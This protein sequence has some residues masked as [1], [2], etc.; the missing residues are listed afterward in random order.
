MAKKKKKTKKA[1]STGAVA[2]PFTKTQLFSEIA[3]G[4]GLSKKEVSSVFEELN[5]IVERHVKKKGCGM[6]TLPGLLK[7]KSRKVPARPAKKNVPN[8][9]KPGEMMDIKA[10]PATVKV[11]VT[12]LK[13]LKDMVI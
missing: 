13:R 4:T 2:S 5:T 8:P 12:P 9:F 11:K 6:F 1:S 7:I 3:E 10:K